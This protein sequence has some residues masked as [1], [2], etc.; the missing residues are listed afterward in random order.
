MAEVT[1]ISVAAKGGWVAAG[2]ANGRLHLW[3]LASVESA[4]RGGIASTAAP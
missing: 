4:L 1:T 2:S 3:P